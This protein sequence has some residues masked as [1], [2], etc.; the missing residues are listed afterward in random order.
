MKTEEEVMSF[1]MSI[2]IR[3]HHR[4]HSPFMDSSL[5][6]THIFT[7]TRTLIRHRYNAQSPI[8]QNINNAII[9]F[10][11]IILKPQ[12]CLSPFPTP[13]LFPFPHPLCVLLRPPASS[14]SLSVP[15]LS[16]PI[17]TPAAAPI[18]DDVA[19]N[20]WEAVVDMYLTGR[21]TSDGVALK[22]ITKGD[23]RRVSDRKLLEKRRTI[24]KTYESLRRAA[25]EYAIGYRTE[26]GIRRK[27]KMYH[28]IS[29]CRVLNAMRKMGEPIPTDPVTLHAVIDTR[30]REKELVKE[31][32]KVSVPTP[33]QQQMTHTD[34]VFQHR[35]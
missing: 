4:K 30:L 13:P 18:V 35:H 29:R 17:P 19:S 33:Q 15:A 7:L 10:N 28:V 8:I 2:L 20:D 24:G 12:S 26:N 1:R 23:G 6:L 5:I 25:F 32:A 34:S 14:R 21:G 31:A 16:T 9:M 22:A 11:N 3:L 27:Q